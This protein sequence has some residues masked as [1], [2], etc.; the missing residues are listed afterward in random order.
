MVSLGGE[1]VMDT[2]ALDADLSGEIAKAEAAISG[3]ADMI[4]REIHQ[5]FGSSLAHRH[6]PPSLYR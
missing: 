6:P 2:R 5:S 4:L 3:I 1:V